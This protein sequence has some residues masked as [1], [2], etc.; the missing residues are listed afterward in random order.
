MIGFVGCGC[1]DGDGI[2][3]VVVIWIVCVCLCVWLSHF[4][5][6]I[7][8]CAG[9]WW[10]RVAFP[11]C[12]TCWQWW[13]ARL[14]RWHSMAW[15]IYCVWASRTQSSTMLLTPM[16]SWLKSATVSPVV[17]TVV[18]CCFCLHYTKCASWKWW[19]L[20]WNHEMHVFSGMSIFRFSAEIFF[21]C[22]WQPASWK[23]SF[24]LLGILHRLLS[25]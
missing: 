20:V 18:V 24:P 1:D 19:K 6:G 17:N 13:T 22:W 5:P 8:M 7:S 9:F 10:T 12:V 25:S 14:C 2:W 21:W 23:M 11:R 16:Q 15:R 3:W 4:Q